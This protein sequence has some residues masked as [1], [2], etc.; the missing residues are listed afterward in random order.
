M[1]QRGVINSAFTASI[2]WGDFTAADPTGNST[3]VTV[4]KADGTALATA[5]AATRTATGVYTWA[6]SPLLSSPD[7]LTLVWS[8]T[9]ASVANTRTTTAEIAGGYTF[10]L[11]QLAASDASLSGYTEAALSDARHAAERDVE[12]VLGFALVPR[13]AIERIIP[14]DVGDIT[15]SWARIRSIRAATVNGTAVSTSSLVIQGN[16]VMAGS[17]DPDYPVTVTYEHGL[18]YAPADLERACMALARIR[19]MAVNSGVP[20]RAERYV[21]ESGRTFVLSSPTAGRVGVPEID[22]VLH[23]Y[24]LP[25][26]A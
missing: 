24:R 5:A 11:A 4:T 26:I 23:R 22:A 25:S 12:R 14:D 16:R 8:G 3:T 6:L 7:I 21:S 20:D 17:F 15:T 1:I 18:D 13:V 9:F 10:T 19:A 2:T